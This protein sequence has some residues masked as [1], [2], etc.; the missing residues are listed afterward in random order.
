MTLSN[1]IILKSLNEETKSSSGDKYETSRAMIQ[2][3]RE[4]NSRQI[5]EIGNLKKQL[6]SIKS[7]KVNNSKVSQGSIDLFHY[8]PIL[9]QVLHH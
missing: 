5:K 6:L 9:H 7:I 8:Q 3:E 2:I 4:K 1:H